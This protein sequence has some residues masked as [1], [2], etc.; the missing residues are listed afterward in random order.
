[1]RASRSRCSGPY[2]ATRPSRAGGGQ[3][4]ALLVEADR[5]DRDVGPPG[6]LLDPKRVTHRAV[7]LGVITPTCPIGAAAQANGVAPGRP[8]SSS[9]PGL[10]FS[11]KA[12]A[13]STA[14]PV[15]ED[16]AAQL[17]GALPGLG[18][19]QLDGASRRAAARARTAMGEFSPMRSASATRLVDAPDRAGTTRL[20]RPS[21]QRALRVDRVAG[22]RELERDRRA[23]RGSASRIR[24]PAAAISPRCTSGMP[25]SAV[26]AATTRSHESTI[27]KPP[28]S[29]GPFTAAMIGFGKSRAHD[30]AR[31]RLAGAR[32]RPRRRSRRP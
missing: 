4:P 16:V 14:S 9:R 31:S 3:Q 17:V 5:V 24:P 23:A 8:V 30:A 15:C 21:V 1:M 13:P 25:N 27:S 7:I 20:T 28:A 18:L 2:Q 12:V 22:H 6:Q 10:R 11:A 32:C 29:A 26:S 19:G